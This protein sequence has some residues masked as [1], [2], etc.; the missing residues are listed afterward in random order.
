MLLLENKKKGGEY[1]DESYSSARLVCGQIQN[2]A[3]SIYVLT[4]F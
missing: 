4:T 2:P 1:Q 3:L